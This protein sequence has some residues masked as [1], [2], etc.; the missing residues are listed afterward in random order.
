MIRTIE[1][2]AVLNGWIA[3]VGCQR[4]VFTEK[5][6]LLDALSS[7]LDHPEQTEANFLKTS[8]NA[9]LVGS[10]EVLEEPESYG[11]G[12]DGPERA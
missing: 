7:Y 5:S 2:G 4:V 8:V 1:I 3:K 12:Q 9:K 11:I 6:A 10:Q